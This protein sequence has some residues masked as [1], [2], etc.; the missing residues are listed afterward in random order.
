[1]L[2]IIADRPFEKNKT[3]AQY[4]DVKRSWT[5]IK[6]MKTT[7]SSV[8]HIFYMTHLLHNRY[9]RVIEQVYKNMVQIL[10]S[11]I[12]HIISIK[13]HTLN[14]SKSGICKINCEIIFKIVWN[15]KSVELNS[16]NVTTSSYI[17]SV[18]FLPLVIS[19]RYLFFSD[20]GF[21]RKKR[22]LFIHDAYYHSC[23]VRHVNGNGRSIDEDCIEFVQKVFDTWKVIRS[24]SRSWYYL[25]VVPAKLLC[26]YLNIVKSKIM[27]LHLIHSP[28]HYSYKTDSETITRVF[29]YRDLG[30]IFDVR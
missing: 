30:V 2:K 28:I 26:L 5:N 15:I 19:S 1:M 16:G 9:T 21:N 29:E 24:V 3:P 22:P 27:S 12:Q 13:D 18:L 11:H 25:W 10:W 17:N 4:N 20:F 8:N 14:L 6:R 23:I 7:V